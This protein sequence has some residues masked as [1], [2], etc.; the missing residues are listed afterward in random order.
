MIKIESLKAGDVLWDCHS[1]RA[2]NT[3]LRREGTWQCQ[4][5]EVAPDGS[6]ALISW[7][8]NKARAYT[9]VPSSWKRHP[10]EWLKSALGPRRCALCGSDEDHGH[11]PDC[12]H[13]R[14]IAA[15]KKAAKAQK[16][17]RP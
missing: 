9:S 10:K 12:D 7:N 11:A 4:V 13:P 5:V 14:A 15:R 2:G 16:E 6:W 1:E 17:P 3:M 8:G